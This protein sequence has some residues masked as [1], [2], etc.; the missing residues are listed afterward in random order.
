MKKSFSEQD[1]EY[2]TAAASN[3]VC[4]G[5]LERRRATGS[6]ACPAPKS[7]LRLGLWLAPCA[8]PRN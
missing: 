6:L 5:R 7:F 3:L 2:R 1:P 8:S 4:I